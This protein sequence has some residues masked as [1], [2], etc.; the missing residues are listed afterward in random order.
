LDEEA[1]IN[2]G[3]NTKRLF[4]KF[5]PA[6]KQ[7]KILDVGCGVGYF[8]YGL[9]QM[10]Y[11][12][13]EGIDYSNE[14]IAAAKKFGL[15]AVE[16][17][18]FEYMS[19]NKSEYDVIIATDILEHLHKDEIIKLL[20]LAHIAMK[21]D[22]IFICAVPNASWPFAPHLRYKDLTHELSFTEETLGEILKV[23]NFEAIYIGG[24]K[25]RPRTVKALIRYVLRVIFRSFWKVFMIAEMGK[26]AIGISLSSKIIA[27][28][29][30]KPSH[31]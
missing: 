20:D 26:D 10:G 2:N 7:A 24:E 19:D 4:K 28:A 5:L 3:R 15:N 14:Q 17:N 21:D 9:K 22:G 30:K 23:T 27:V 25:S 16:G 6:N 29:Q 8:L 13:A 31:G 12:N 1:Y 11:T 18:L